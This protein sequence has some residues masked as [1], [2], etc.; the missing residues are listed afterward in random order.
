VT[1]PTDERK[2][3]SEEKEDRGGQ[4]PRFSFPFPL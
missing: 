3:R 4:I 2:K 1:N